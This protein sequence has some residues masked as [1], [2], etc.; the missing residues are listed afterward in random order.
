MEEIV[1]SW[2]VQLEQDAK[3]FTDEAVKVAGWDMTLRETQ[4]ELF[5]LADDVQKL[6]LG[7][8]DLERSMKSIEGEQSQLDN[9][10]DQL[11]EQA[12]KLMQEQRG[13]VPE[14]GDVEREQAYHIAQTVDM[15]LAGMVE[16]LKSLVDQVNSSS[17]SPFA[18]GGGGGG[19]GDAGGDSNARKI[20]RILNAHHHSLAWLEDSSKRML[21]D[22][23]DV[24]RRLGMPSDAALMPP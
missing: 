13:Q 21:L 17:S 3:T 23:S 1:N 9:T 24:S 2:N 5:S 7:Q 15:Q 22:A 14:E 10:L 12:E 20:V 16:T 4:S 18:G 8:Q 19:G 11:E 6:V